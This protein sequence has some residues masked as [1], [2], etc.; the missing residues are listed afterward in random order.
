M[1]SKK[2][3]KVRAGTL[4][5]P[6][7]RRPEKRAEKSIKKPWEKKPRKK[8][9]HSHPSRRQAPP[10][11]VLLRVGPHQV[12]HRPLV[13]HLLLP[14]Q[15]ADR[16]QGRHGGA[17]PAVHRKHAAR[18]DRRRE[19]QVVEAVGA[20][21]PDVGVAVLAH[22]LV[23]EAVDLGDLAAL[24]VAADQR[25]AV[26]VPHLER[27]QQQEGLDRVEA[28]VDKVP[29]EEVGC[30]RGVPAR[31][32]QLAQVV[33]LPV[34]V[35]ADG[36]RGGDL[37]DVPLLDEQLDGRGAELL[38]LALGERA[39]GAELG[40]PRVEVH[41][42]AFDLSLSLSAP[43]RWSG[44]DGREREGGGGRR[45]EFFAGKR[46]RGR[47]TTKELGGDGE[48]GRVECSSL[49]LPLAG[50]ARLHSTQRGE[51][52]VPRARCTGGAVARA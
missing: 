36:D 51:R 18:V 34:D 6:E 46:G 11:D 2:G 48:S 3:R 47:T 39:A 42:A 26:R 25:D 13:R 40:D 52:A 4:P 43:R 29:E 22:A 28:A 50:G 17:E 19:R 5:S 38:G 8:K 41:F 49:L 12:A 31:H 24:V 20:G 15:R 21:A 16:V 23:V 7:K 9:H 45:T 33:E 10:I 35:A 14:V 37:R 32:E 27:Q 30:P 1:F 44:G